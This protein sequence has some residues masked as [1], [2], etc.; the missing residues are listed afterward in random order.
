M[1]VKV[2]LEL[3]LPDS[4]YGHPNLKGKW[5]MAHAYQAVNDH[6]LNYAICHHSSDSL[7][8][9]GDFVDGKKATDHIEWAKLLTKAE[10]SLKIEKIGD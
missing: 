7:K 5:Q 9:K 3:E 1:K 2:T 4:V 10:P 8:N 6:F